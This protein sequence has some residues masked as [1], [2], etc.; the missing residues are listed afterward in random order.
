[1]S[2]VKYF[3]VRQPDA[4]T[5]KFGH[6]GHP[7]GCVAY[8][9]VENGV[10]YAL[11]TVNLDVDQFNRQDART[12]ALL[13]LT[14]KTASGEYDPVLIYTDAENSTEVVSDIM[15][16]LYC[17][18]LTPSRVKKAAKKWLWPDNLVVVE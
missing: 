7:V 6:R 17:D 11:S 16:S 10:E 2:N 15:F 14:D 5:K 3:F 13:R 9:R 18:G 8:R 1:M 12:I 4:N